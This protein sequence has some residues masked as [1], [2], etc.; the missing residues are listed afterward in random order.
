MKRICAI[1]IFLGIFCS[2]FSEEVEDNQKVNNVMEESQNQLLNILN[3]DSGELEGL[4][5]LQENSEIFVMENEETAKKNEEARPINQIKKKMKNKPL[6][7]VS[8]GAD[9]PFTFKSI[10]ENMFDK[11]NMEGFPFGIILQTIT[12]VKLWSFK[13]NVSFDFAKYAG[14]DYGFILSPMLS[15]GISPIHNDYLFLGLYGTVGG[16]VIGDYLFWSGGLSGSVVFNFTQKLGLFVNVDATY[17][18]GE[19]YSGDGNAPTN[20]VELKNTWRI[21][22]SI[23]IT[24]RKR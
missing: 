1:L 22:P 23:G 3:E 14:Y 7:Y 4:D 24:F 15:L 10:Q 18:F 11:D 6:W 8:L 2:A 17:R 13:G 20:R 12:V 21:V 16:E 9:I 19:T 5:I